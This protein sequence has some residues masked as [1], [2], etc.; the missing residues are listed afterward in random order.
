MTQTPI[1]GFEGFAPLDLQVQGRRVRGRVG[2]RPD[3]PPL[4]LLPNGPQLTPLHTSKPVPDQRNNP[5]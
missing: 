3:A 5:A 2:G 1:P 4:L